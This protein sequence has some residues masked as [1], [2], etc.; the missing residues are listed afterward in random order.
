[1]K[2][3]FQKIAVF[4]M[5]LTVLFS[6]MS[7]TVDKHYCGDFL[8]SVSLVTKAKPCGMEVKK[9]MST[10]KCT[11]IKKHCCSNETVLIDGSNVLKV[12]INDLDLDQQIFI[13]SYIYSYINLFEGLTENVIPFKEYSP[14]LLVTNIQLTNELFLI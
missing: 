1:M 10:D 13:T 8:V 11:V 9:T 3:I 2:P 4:T 12:S 5:A 7:F 6:T 14:P